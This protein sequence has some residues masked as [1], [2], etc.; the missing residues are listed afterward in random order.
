M[1]EVTVEPR[2]LRAGRACDLEIKLHNAGTGTCTD[3]VFRIGLPPG[4]LLLRGR[5]RVEVA[6]LGAGQTWV[7]RLTVRPRAPGDFPITSTNF[8]YRDEHGWPARVP[9]FRAEAA[10]LAVPDEP[11]PELSAGVVSGPLVLGEWGVL[12][13]RVRNSGPPALRDLGLALTGPVLL[14]PPGQAHIPELAPGG[15]GAEV[16]FVVCPTAPGSHVPAQVRITFA[17]GPGRSHPLDLPIRLAV[18]SHAADTRPP[19]AGRGEAPETILFLAASP[20]DLADLRSA[21][22]MREIR[23]RLQLGRYRDRFRLESAHAV[24]ISDLGQALAD[25]E[26]RIVHFSGHGRRD[27]SLYL[28]NDEGYSAPAS[29]TGLGKLFGLHAETVECVIVNACDT[30]L[31]AQAISKRIDHVI[32][33]RC[34]VG[35]AAAITFSIGFY[36]GL[37]A[38]ASVVQAFERGRAFLQSQTAGRPEHD[39][40]VLLGPGGQDLS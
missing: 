28:Q 33:M 11:G 16:S 30:L 34:P 26:P 23:E 2:E 21:R 18:P 27:G 40:A 24:R 32:A 20:V 3:I 22:E 31:L 1:I 6:E 36:Q 12:R 38:G 5:N 17:D 39:A 8:S 7:H 4:A 9:G 15:E 13:L 29:A 19:A 37:A 14:A 10:V 35:D 25:Y